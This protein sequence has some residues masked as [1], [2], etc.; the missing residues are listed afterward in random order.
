MNALIE[1][2]TDKTIDEL[3][4]ILFDDIKHLLNSREDIEN[5]LF[6]TRIMFVDNEELIEFINK[7]MQFG[8]EDMALDYVEN[9]YD[10]V[11]LD[12]S[13]LKKYENSSK[14]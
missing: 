14:Q 2:I 3:D 10:K 8:Y 4:G 1:Q 13:K 6:T 12:F 7:L 5:V 11:M 9:I